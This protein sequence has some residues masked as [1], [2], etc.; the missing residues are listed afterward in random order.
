[1]SSTDFN[2]GRELDALVAEKMMGYHEYVDSN[3]K[4]VFRTQGDSV[5]HPCVKCRSFYGHTMKPYS[6][7]IAAAWEVVDEMKKRGYDIE[8]RS[9]VIG[10]PWLVGFAGHPHVNPFTGET[11]PHAICLAAL[12]AV[13]KET[14]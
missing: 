12:A 14:K 4:E 10:R 6:T 1:M 3:P 13:T 9:N 11:A 2:P 7:S 8:I 5:D